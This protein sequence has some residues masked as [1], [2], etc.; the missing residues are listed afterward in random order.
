MIWIDQLTWRRFDW[1]NQVRNETRR[2]TR[3]SLTIQQKK[4]TDAV[5]GK[6]GLTYWDALESEVW[7]HMTFT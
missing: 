5:N 7:H 4:F 1:L 3:S 2:D 6:S